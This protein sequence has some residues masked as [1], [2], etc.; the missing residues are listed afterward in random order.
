MDRELTI[1]YNNFEQYATCDQ[2]KNK[3]PFSQIKK[4]NLFFVE[5]RSI[6]VSALA[7]GSGSLGRGSELFNLFYLISLFNF[8]VSHHDAEDS[9][10]LVVAV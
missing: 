7:F 5:R 10:R 9:T 8:H 1:H 6:V 4:L 2:W 3:Y